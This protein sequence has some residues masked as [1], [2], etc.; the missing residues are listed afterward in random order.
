M[1]INS[2]CLPL[3]NYDTPV[4]IHQGLGMEE[5]TISQHVVRLYAMG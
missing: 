5:K 1:R 4:Q 2:A 3:Q